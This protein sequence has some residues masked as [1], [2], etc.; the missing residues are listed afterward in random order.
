MKYAVGMGS[1]C[2]I[3]I[4]FWHSTIDMYVCIRGPCTA[5]FNDLLQ[6][7]WGIHWHT[8][9]MYHNS[10]VMHTFPNFCHFQ[11]ASAGIN[12]CKNS[13]WGYD[14]AL[15]W[16]TFATHF[17]FRGHDTFSVSTKAACAPQQRREPVNLD[18]WVS[19]IRWSRQFRWCCTGGF[20]VQNT[21]LIT[22]RMTSY[23]KG[24]GGGGENLCKGNAQTFSYR[25]CIDMSLKIAPAQFHLRRWSQY[26]T[27]I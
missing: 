14:I 18:K 15:G 11:C 17:L 20:D 10:H 16:F 2:M 26:N 4:P 5:T 9:G 25:G 7:I 8:E 1:G 13:L 6:L 21:H 12:K 27:E 3:Y 19:P 24:N 22:V 23:R